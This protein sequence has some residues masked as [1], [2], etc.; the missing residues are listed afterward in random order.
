MFAPLFEIRVLVK[1][2]GGGGQKYGFASLGLGRGT[3]HRLL[4]R[5]GDLVGNL[6]DLQGEIPRRMTDQIG[7]RDPAQ[8]RHKPGN[9][10]LLAQTAR[11]PTDILESLQGLGR[12]VH[13]RGLGIVDEADA[14]DF[15][16][17]LAAMGQSGKA[18]QRRLDRARSQADGTTGGIGR[19]GVLV[20]MGAG[21]PLDGTQ[22]DRARLAAF[23]VFGQK[24]LSRKDRPRGPIQLLS[25]RDPDHAVIRRSHLHLARQIQPFDLIDAD[26]RPVRPA[27]GKEPP[28]G[29]KI[30]ARPAVAVQMIGRK[31]REDGDIRGQRAGQI[32]L[33]AGQFQHHDL[34]VDGGLQR[35]HTRADIPTH[36]RRAPAF[37]KYMV[38]QR[39]RRRFAVR[40][41]DRDH[42]RRTIKP[43]PI[44]GGVAA[45]EQP[46]I[47]V[48]R[49]PKR[50][51]RC[52][53]RMRP[54]VKMRNSRRGDQRRHAMPCLIPRQIYDPQPFG[55]GGRSGIDAVIPGDDCCPTSCQRR[56]RGLARPA[57]T[58]HRDCLF[59]NALDRDHAYF[60]MS[61]PG[62]VCP[63]T[64]E[65]IRATAKA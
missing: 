38:D 5:L 18:V 12:R 15:A 55:F 47:V 30:A 60:L 16:H 13:I 27:L 9:S 59:F 62:A 48:H 42:T 40:A 6:P 11:D 26:H 41:G 29:R 28:L 1:A 57:K 52:D 61:K 24:T 20:I 36:L 58:E 25:R 44:G 63:R 45:K 54:R 4:H 7:F 2:C 32:G 43:L 17:Q 31:I 23:A 37:F 49:H 3:G 65:D 34:A 33:I 50:V 53:H 10:A 51:G 14:V 21:Q 46:D 56:R 22:I 39:R 35:Q 64:P 8:M 19:A